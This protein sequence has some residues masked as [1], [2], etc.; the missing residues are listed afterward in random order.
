MFSWACVIKLCMKNV[1]DLHIALLLR[2]FQKRK[3]KSSLYSLRAYARD[4]GIHPS[5]LSQILRSNRKIPHATALKIVKKL[6]LSPSSAQDFLESNK[7]RGLLDQVEL[8]DVD[9][10]F[11]LDEDMFTVISEYEHYVVLTLLDIEDFKGSAE[12][13]S[14]KMGIPLKR[15]TQ[16]IENLLSSGLV[17]KV[18]DKL[19]KV[20]AN[21]RTNEDV[22]SRALQASHLEALEMAK[23]KLTEIPVSLR[24]FSEV[25]ITVSP[26]MLP[27][28]KEAIREFRYKAQSIV[29]RGNQTDVYKLA[30]QLYPMTVI[31][32]A[33]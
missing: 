22:F 28:L 20:H 23:S 6:K 11:L 1:K 19:E 24:D 2:E 4:I 3:A 32:G 15:A 13:V 14:T 18:D 10:R 17:K 9:E 7:G 12:E 21:V 33:D 16:V 30:I 31:Q 29:S 8:S 27:E 5:S 26:D 25:T